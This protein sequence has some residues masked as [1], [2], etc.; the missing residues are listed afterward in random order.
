MKFRK[1][2][3]KCFTRGKTPVYEVIIHS[4]ST[5]IGKDALN[6]PF[7]DKMINSMQLQRHFYNSAIFFMK[8][9]PVSFSRRKHVF[10]NPL[11]IFT[12]LQGI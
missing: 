4:I 5:G 2:T 11:L 6:I 8:R 7:G 10:L 1:K 12:F 3:H 9:L